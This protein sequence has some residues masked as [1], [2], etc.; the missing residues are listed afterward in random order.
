M[1]WWPVRPWLI[2]RWPESSAHSYSAPGGSASEVR[3]R[4]KGC[5]LAQAD[6]ARKVRSVNGDIKIIPS[7]VTEP[8][9][10]GTKGNEAASLTSRNQPS[11]VSVKSRAEG[12][13][14]TKT[15]ACWE[16]MLIVRSN[17]MIA[18]TS[19]WRG[20]QLTQHVK[21]E[22]QAPHGPTRFSLG[23]FG[24]PPQ[25]T[26]TFCF[27]VSW[28]VWP[29]LSVSYFAITQEDDT[30]NIARVSDNPGNAQLM[31]VKLCWIKDNIITIKIIKIESWSR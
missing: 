3:T 10:G 28:R 15:N 19:L 26:P 21:N 6:H 9:S 30:R 13:W 11:R 22:G 2:Y 4:Q 27:S 17:A 20:R 5:F 25:L 14:A 23:F 18:P 8:Q 29:P 16:N 24:K 1:P 7:E 31:F 12:Q